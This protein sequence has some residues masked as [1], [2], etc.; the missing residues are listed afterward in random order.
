MAKCMTTA[1]SD[2]ILNKVAGAVPNACTYVFQLAGSSRHSH[3]AEEQGEAQRGQ[4]HPD[5]EGQSWLRPHLLTSQPLLLTSARPCQT[6][7]KRLQNPSIAAR[8]QRRRPLDS[9]CPHGFFFFFL[10]SLQDVQCFGLFIVFIKCVPTISATVCQL[11]GTER[12]DGVQMS[13]ETFSKVLFEAIVL[14][15]EQ[16]TTSLNVS[17][18]WPDLEAWEGFPAFLWLS[19]Q[20][21]S[22][23]SLR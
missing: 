21:E 5:G 7:Y 20:E 23:R 2:T 18:T 14:P 8:R 9:R 10:K 6:G 3:S 1:N 19:W 16:I 13:G 17:L 12:G 22:H 4:G 15:R 11:S